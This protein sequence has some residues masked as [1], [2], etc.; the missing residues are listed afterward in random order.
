MQKFNTRINKAEKQTVS[1]QLRKKRGAAIS[2]NLLMSCCHSRFLQKEE[3]VFE[4]QAACGKSWR[5]ERVPKPFPDQ[6]IIRLSAHSGDVGPRQQAANHL[7]QLP[8]WDF[9]K[10]P[11]VPLNTGPKSHQSGRC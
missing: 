7:K 5:C 11:S 6:R 8:S 10:E 3:D 1:A 9:N 4:T 2:K